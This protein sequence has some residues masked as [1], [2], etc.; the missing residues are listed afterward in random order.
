[1]LSATKRPQASL[2]MLPDISSNATDSRVQARSRGAAALD[3]FSGQ[4][5]LTKSS[6]FLGLVNGQA[7]LRQLQGCVPISAQAGLGKSAGPVRWHSPTEN[8][9]CGAEGR[10]TT[11]SRRSAA[12]GVLDRPASTDEE[13]ATVRGPGSRDG[14]VGTDQHGR[15]APPK[16]APKRPTGARPQ[17]A[18][19][20][21]VDEAR[22]HN[23]GCEQSEKQEGV[24][25]AL[26]D[27]REKVRQQGA[28]SLA[29]EK[30]VEFRGWFPPPKQR[31]VSEVTGRMQRPDDVPERRPEA[32]R[33]SE[34]IPTEK[35][36][37]PPKSFERRAGT[38]GRVEREEF[39]FASQAMALE[40]RGVAVKPDVSSDGPSTS[41]RTG[42][43]VRSNVSGRSRQGHDDGAVLRREVEGSG[44]ETVSDDS[45]EE[46]ES[47]KVRVEVAGEHITYDSLK[48]NDVDTAVR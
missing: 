30:V 46:E 18:F 31:F 37:S 6:C 42:S 27:R 9:E 32:S 25:R 19:S 4:R 1:M 22:L 23:L 3:N 7:A 39:S 8:R 13:R 48:K 41:G 47:R 36:P 15:A 24:W 38:S 10:R 29:V 11:G 44:F 40:K 34:P 16:V 21:G 26:V 2:A 17:L 43:A 5:A 45:E 20:G 14:R 28:R 35:R 33:S 12:G